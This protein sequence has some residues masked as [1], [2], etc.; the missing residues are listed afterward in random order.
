MKIENPKGIVGKEVFDVNGNTIGYVDK[1]WSSWNKE[2]PGYFFGIRPNQN[3]RDT[4]FRGTHKLVPIYSDYIR[5]V[6]ECIT[7]N[8][9]MDDLY[10]FWSKTVPCG[11]NT[12]PADEL[13]EMPV[14]DK[15]HSRVGTFFASVETGSTSNYGVLVD[16]FLCETWKAP[17]NTLM[18]IPTSYITHVRDTITL[19]K[20]L[21]E[22]KEYWKQHYNF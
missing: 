17:P 19:D 9:T 6:S 1:T 16:P 7:L 14:Y 8:K 13:V 20:T 21:D 22:L 11:T 5:E 3:A 18:P 12:C 4:C 2:S 15:N 10:R